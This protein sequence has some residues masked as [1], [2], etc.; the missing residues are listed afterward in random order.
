MRLCLALGH[1]LKEFD[2]NSYPHELEYWLAYNQIEPIPQP[3]LQAGVI[4]S[5]VARANGSKTAKPSGFMPAHRPFKSPVMD[6]AEM[7]RTFHENLKR[8]GALIDKRDHAD[9]ARSTSHP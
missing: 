2:E 6:P 4:A 1:T 8:A 5:T 9:N 3:W 7:Q